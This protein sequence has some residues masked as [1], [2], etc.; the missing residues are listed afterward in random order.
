MSYELMDVLQ[1]IEYLMD[2][3]MTED[4]ACI[5]TGGDYNE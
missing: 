3:G 5:I 2:Q 1:Q 4:Q